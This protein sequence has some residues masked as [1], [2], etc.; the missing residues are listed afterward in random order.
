MEDL[1]RCCGACGIELETATADGDAV[2]LLEDGM[3]L[4]RSCAMDAEREYELPPLETAA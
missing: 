3:A 2:G 4:C 1:L